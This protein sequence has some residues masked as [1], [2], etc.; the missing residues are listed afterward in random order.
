MMTFTLALGWV[1]KYLLLFNLE[2]QARS[3]H[4]LLGASGNN[5]LFYSMLIPFVVTLLVGGRPFGLDC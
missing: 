2:S 1:R 4:V 3:L 5:R